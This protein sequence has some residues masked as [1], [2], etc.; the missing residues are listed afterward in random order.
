MNK[1]DFLLVLI[2]TNVTDK[3]LGFCS[4][5]FLFPIQGDSEQMGKILRGN[6]THLQGKFHFIK[7]YGQR[8]NR[9][10]LKPE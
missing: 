7:K 2:F 10:L 5:S 3:Q 8:A 4:L 1:L 9:E 6:R